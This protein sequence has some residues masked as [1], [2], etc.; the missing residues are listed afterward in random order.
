MK[1]G[2]SACLLGEKV[3][4]D[5]TDKRNDKII[6]LVKGHEVIAICPEASAGFPLPHEPLEI[7]NNKVFTQSGI[8]ATEKLHEGSRKCLEMIKDCDLLILKSK[9]PSCGYGKIYDGS[10]S[11][12]LI[13]GN[14][15]FT[16]LSLKNGIAVF[17]ETQIEEIEKII[18]QAD[19][20]R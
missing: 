7:L 4:Y 14:G 13:K 20:D 18:S 1:I 3:R 12:K 15:V 5:L 17:N 2:I 16:D 6:E 8:D 11:G 9:S 19:C 10:F